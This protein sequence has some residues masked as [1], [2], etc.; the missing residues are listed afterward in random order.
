MSSRCRHLKISRSSRQAQCPTCFAL[1]PTL[2]FTSPLGDKKFRAADFICNSA[3]QTYVKFAVRL[4]P[5]AP[6]VNSL[7]FVFCRSSLHLQH[8]HISNFAEGVNR[9]LK[10]FSRFFTL[11]FNS[12]RTVLNNTQEARQRKGFLRI[13]VGKGIS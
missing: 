3:S 5:T 7:L 2:G 13:F 4:N 11:E 9:F 10:V 1:V 6:T 12:E 8:V